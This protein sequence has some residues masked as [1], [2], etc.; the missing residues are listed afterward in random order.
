VN[1]AS[2]TSPEGWY[3]DFDLGRKFRHARGAT[4]GEVEN[5]FISKHVMNTSDSHWNEDVMQRRGYED[6]RLV[7]GLITASMVF[8]LASQDTAE[9]AITEMGCTGLRFLKPV[10]HGDTLYA[11]TEVVGR[12]AAPERTDAGVVRFHHWGV[13]QEGVVVFE[14][15]RSVLVKR[16]SSW[17]TE[18]AD[19]SQPARNV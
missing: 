13:N 10:H 6:G 19:H 5:G 7:F 1:L 8:G 2:L 17:A 16:K 3:E 11:Y 18:Q 12:E 14:G 15:E 9:N 4:V